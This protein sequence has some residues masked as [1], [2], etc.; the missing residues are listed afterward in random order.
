MAQPGC[1]PPDA[2]FRLPLPPLTP[3]CP[4]V[5][6]IRAHS[7]PKPSGTLTFEPHPFSSPSRTIRGGQT[8]DHPSSKPPPGSARRY[9]AGHAHRAHGD[10]PPPRPGPG[11]ALPRA[12]LPG[13]QRRRLV[14]QVASIGL[15]SLHVTLIEGLSRAASSRAPPAPTAAGHPQL[16]PRGRP[17][18]PTPARTARLNWPTAGRA[19]RPNRP[20]S[21]RL[22][23]RCAGSPRARA[24]AAA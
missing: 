1:S 24:G 16:T 9:P 23:G 8:N 2:N 21:S 20:T 7:R 19:H 11:A 5:P 14:F 10:A 6:F 18:S 3:S 22:R 12:G 15:H 17:R 13:Q 4:F